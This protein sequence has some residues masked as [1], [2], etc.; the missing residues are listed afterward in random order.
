[1]LKKINLGHI[2]LV[3]VA[4][5][6]V[7]AFYLG[8]SVVPLP[9]TH[10][11]VSYHNL[12]L[13]VL[14]GHGF[15]FDQDWWPLT[16]AGAPTAHWSYLYTLYL[17]AVYALFG[18]HP[19]IARLIQAIAVGLLQPYLAHRIAKQAFGVRSTA[20]ELEPNTS[21]GNAS[22]SSPLSAPTEQSIPLIAAGITAVYSYFIYYAATLMTEPFF[23][24]ALMGTLLLAIILAFRIDQPRYQIWSVGFGLAMSITVLLR[25]L[26]LLLV[27]LILLWLL[28]SMYAARRSLQKGIIAVVTC[29]TILALS[30]L[31]FTLFN[32]SRFDSF[33]LLNT[34]S[35]YVLFWAN[36]PIY[37][38]EFK[39]AS[40]MG[41][42]Y[43]E[44]IPPELRQLDE[45]ALDRALLQRGIEFIVAEPG[46]Y[47]LLSLSRIPE[48]FK[49]WPE[50]T[51]SKI[52]N[53]ARVGSWGIFL[54]F[55]LYGLV[56]SWIR[57]RRTPHKRWLALVGSPTALLYLFV[58]AY[59][60]IHLLTW[61]QVRYR[62]PVDAI[63]VLFAALALA[64]IAEWIVKVR[65]DA[66][67]KRG[68]SEHSLAT[69]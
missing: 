21:V 33:V 52:S 67:G 66:R 20:A 42:S 29:L 59:S 5:R 45:A 53:I 15:T 3:S 30:I 32:Y 57:L 13:R 24:V 7:A 31:P 19:L 55:I 25:Q 10:D 4:L 6:V 16:A 51:S 48:Y 28:L 2:L 39:S 11:Q 36:H 9:G 35:G 8:D 23:I 60:T 46:R 54:P 37:G 40:E 65:K 58:G 49:F 50:S 22:S 69:D 1:M 26:F 43:G 38:T 62:V 17:V 12:A 64:H 14:D 44:L 56:L 47:A 41:N 18:P 68:A 27:P 63:L 61:S 34:N